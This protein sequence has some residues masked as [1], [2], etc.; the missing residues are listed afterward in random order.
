[1][2]ESATQTR[3]SVR[4]LLLIAALMGIWLRLYSHAEFTIGFLNFVFVCAFF[5]TPLFAIRPVLRLQPKPRIWGIVLLTPVM[6][7]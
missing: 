5:A 7:L 1:M 2:A 6:L 3:R 4:Q